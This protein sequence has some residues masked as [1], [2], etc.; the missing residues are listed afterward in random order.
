[1]ESKRRR[2]RATCSTGAGRRSAGRA[3]R[4]RR[5]LRNQRPPARI[6]VLKN[7]AFELM[8]RSVFSARAPAEPEQSTIHRDAWK[9]GE[10]RRAVAISHETA[11]D[12]LSGFG[13]GPNTRKSDD[14]RCR[15]FS[16][17]VDRED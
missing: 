12:N 17:T 7:P 11:D 13:A 9:T 14:E 6:P 5:E 4:Q 3:D 16:T 10:I 15:E 8:T 2:I 1:M